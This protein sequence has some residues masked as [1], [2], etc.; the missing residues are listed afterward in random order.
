MPLPTQ[1]TVNTSDTMRP[2]RLRA[3][4]YG[5]PGA[6]KTTLAGGWY[7]QSTLII[8]T[9]GGTRFLPG[10]HYVETPANFGQF[11][12]IVNELTTSQHQFTTLVVDSIDNLVRMVD[13]EAGKRGGKVAAGLVEFGKGLADRD[14]SLMREL[15]RITLAT[16]LGLI[17]VAHPKEREEQVEGLKD[18][19][20][21]VGPRIDPNGRI[22]QEIEGLVD[23]IFHVGRDHVVT[24]GGS[25]KYVTKR[26]VALPDQLPADAGQLYQAI[27]AG[28][29]AIGTPNNTKEKVAA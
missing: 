11:T 17:L 4:L 10:A 12:Q 25:E 27:N 26:R 5:P 16:D 18:P 13:E 22:T 14:G 28:V 23:F 29:A 24:T 1:T 7:P 21:T 19:R 20:T 2:D 9:E 3:I 8:D 6:G 15:R